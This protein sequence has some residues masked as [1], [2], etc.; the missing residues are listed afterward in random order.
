MEKIVTGPTAE[1]REHT[2]ADESC[3]QAVL[4]DNLREHEATVREVIHNHKRIVAWTFFFALSAVGWGFDAQVN[5]AA[6][7]VPSFRRDFG[8]VKIYCL[9][10]N[11]P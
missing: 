6:I 10:L 11:L 1:I 5:G 7:S 2:C 9:P 8:Y 3:E 4:A